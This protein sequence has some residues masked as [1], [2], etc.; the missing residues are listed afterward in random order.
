MK[1][2]QILVNL[3][4]YGYLVWYLYRV[5][6]HEWDPWDAFVVLFVLFV[7]IVMTCMPSLHASKTSPGH[8]P[9]AD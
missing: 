7:A 3:G 2:V 1:L 4:L 6:I 8:Y 5:T 9:Y